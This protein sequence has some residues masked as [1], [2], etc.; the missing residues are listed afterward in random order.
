MYVNDALND[1]RILI[2]MPNK[3]ISNYVNGLLSDFKGQLKISE[4]GANLIQEI[5]EFKP[6]CIIT[7]PQL[8]FDKKDIYSIVRNETIFC[9]A[10]ILF[11]SF[12]T[13]PFNY[14]ELDKSISY[15]KLPV[16][17]EQF[18]IEI[19]KLI[20]K[21]KFVLM[22]D[23]SILIHKLLSQV[24]KENNYGVLEAFNGKEAIE[25]LK[26]SKPDIIITDIEMPEMNG[27]DFCKAVKQNSETEH[28]PVIILSSL[29]GGID[30][31]RG[32]DAGANDY[33]TKP[34]DNEELL[35]RLTNLLST[36]KTFIR[37][38]ILVVDDSKLIRNMMIQ[39]FE[40]QGF[41]VAFG[42]NGEDG[43]K[44]AE[45]FEPDLI[46]TDYDMPVL[47][48][49]GFCQALRKDKRFKNIPV[50]MLTSRDSK[51]DKAKS[52]GTGVKAYL[53]KP[54]TVDKLISIVERTLAEKRMEREREVLKLYISDSAMDAVM[55]ASSQKKVSSKTRAKKIFG[56]VIFTDLKSFTPT[57]ESLTPKQIMELLNDYFDVM[58]AILKKHDA[59]IDKFIGDAI[60]A[61][62]RN[63]EEGAYNAVAAGLEMVQ[64]IP[65]FNKERS[66]PLHMRVGINSGNVF[67]GDLGS[68][69][70]RLDFTVIGDNV[71]IAQ[72]LESNCPVDGVL[73]SE[74]TYQLVKKY[75]D[76][77]D[78]G[79][80][81]LKGKKDKL[82]A[83][84]VLN[85][86][87]K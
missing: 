6:N 28:L 58:C 35:N 79:P 33:L 14:L 85:V 15:L 24:L 25:I 31:D 65:D 45:E 5:D 22:V 17:K 41:R 73:I 48:G 42:V 56:T 13:V 40:Q 21:R 43:I 37:E 55:N 27:Y 59:V 49:W 1:K 63:G 74:S 53:T 12:D 62:C 20:F 57:C 77:E 29:K 38:K 84:S 34:I 32:F 30:I 68:K 46:T 86:K 36:S 26:T 16:N 81:A 70:H 7:Y 3:S 10:S 78:I 51:S 44:V 87:S 11:V 83:Y 60:M 67:C 23:D 52:A 61:L 75:V 19:D 66:T 72:R 39:G 9:E 4:I 71:N 82:N 54:F 47:D 2:L 64:A 50:I 8:K 80:I 76:V 18:I 69:H